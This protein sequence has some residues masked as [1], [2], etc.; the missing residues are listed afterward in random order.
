V[1]GSGAANGAVSPIAPFVHLPPLSGALAPTCAQGRPVRDVGRLFPAIAPSP[2]IAP[3]AS[4]APSPGAFRTGSMRHET[5]VG[6]DG[7]PV[8]EPLGGHRLAGLIFIV[9]LA[10]GAVAGLWLGRTRNRRVP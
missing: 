8:S 10:A 7:V 9:V 4:A 6:D 1:N 5:L 3:S 2:G